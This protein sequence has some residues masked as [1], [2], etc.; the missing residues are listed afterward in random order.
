MFAEVALVDAL[1]TVLLCLWPRRAHQELLLD[2]PEHKRW[3]VADRHQRLTEVGAWLAVEGLLPAELAV[4]ERT[5]ATDRAAVVADLRAAIALEPGAQRARGA[6][7]LL[8]AI[9]SATGA[10]PKTL[11]NSLSQGLQSHRRD[12]RWLLSLHRCLSVPVP[13]D[14]WLFHRRSPASITSVLAGSQRKGAAI[15]GSDLDLCVESRDPVTERQ[16][17]DLRRALEA[18]LR[19]P[20]LVLSHAVRLPSHGG[21]A[22]VDI[23]FANA[24][25]GSRPL[26]DP[27]DFHNHRGRQLTVRALKVWTRSGG[28][29]SVP[30]WAAE[31][32]VVHLDPS[33][34]TLSGFGLFTRL[35][36]WLADRATPMAIEGV[37]RPA[38]YPRWNPVWSTRLPGRLEAL[39]NH[40]RALRRRR[41]RPEDWTSNADVER[42]LCG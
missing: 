2:L 27:A 19:R 3:T 1:D 36:E 18:E 8:T 38:A 28:L 4:P 23:A 10:Q 6:S 12:H 7:G 20:A 39:Q 42:W 16:R 26:P 31:A 21:S 14:A 17:R 5:P 32:L 29:P 24:A 41:P 40:V 9:A 30:G 13:L 25:F 34:G 15:S 33:S 22:K 11:G 37:L 35:V